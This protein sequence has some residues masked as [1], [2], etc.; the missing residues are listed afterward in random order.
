MTEMCF[1]VRSMIRLRA[2]ALTAIVLNAPAAFAQTPPVP[3][4]TFAVLAG[5]AVTCTN[6]SVIGDVGVWPGPTVT[7][8]ACLV[9]GG[10]VHQS[11]A[12][13]R[14]AFMNFTS[15]Y[16]QLRAA[17][18]ANCRALP[19][20]PVIFPG[21]YCLTAAQ[22]TQTGSAWTLDSR[23][24][25]NATW[26]FYVDA[27]LTGT[28]FVMTMAGG[29]AC[30]VTWWVGAGATLTDSTFLGTVL[31]GAAITATDSTV[32]GDLWATAAATLTRSTVTGC[33][34][35]NPGPVPPPDMCKEPDDDDHGD[36]H[37]HHGDHGDKDHG[38]GGHG[39]DDHHKGDHGDNDHGKGDR[40]DNDHGKDDKDWDHK[41]KD[42]GR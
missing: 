13:A 33:R 4:R 10:T 32:A 11:D 14:Q 36:G 28:N 27:A 16:D 20:G 1:S 39:D 17:R 31:A 23:G 41:G 7:Q 34:A 18:P 6:S 9:T 12:A 19:L 40:D 29:R 26:R 21:V 42:K 30:N 35:A 5:A 25:P 37:H 3:A 24:N 15:T 22:S 38:K 2:I 8:T